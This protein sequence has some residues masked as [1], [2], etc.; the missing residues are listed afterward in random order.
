[1]NNILIGVCIDIGNSAVLQKGDSYYL[2]PHGDKHYYV[3][4]FPNKNAHKG[5]F[6]A[7]LFQLINDIN[8]PHEPEA[9]T[10]ELE[11]E[12][13]YKAPLVWRNPGYKSKE[14]KHYFIKPKTTHC[15]FY[16]DKELKEFCGCFPLHWISDFEELDVS[17][18]EIDSENNSFVEEELALFEEVNNGYEQLSLF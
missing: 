3:S 13:I 14:L 15:Y 8:W 5:C 4:K 6:H 17:A 11:R 2:F 16:H 7:E 10:P 1:V 18:E 12:K 9:I